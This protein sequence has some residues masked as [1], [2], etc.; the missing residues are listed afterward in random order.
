MQRV[1]ETGQAEQ[2][3]Q[4]Q[5]PVP[6]RPNEVTYWLASYFSVPLPGG[7]P[8]IGVMGLDITEQKKVEQRLHNANLLLQGSIDGTPDLIAAMGKDFRYLAVNIPYQQAFKQVFGKEVQAGTNLVDALAHLPEDQQNAKDLWERALQGERF[9]ITADFGDPHR[10]RR[11]FEMHFYPIYDAEG[12]IIAAG[13]IA[14]DVTERLK[15]EQALQSSIEKLTRSNEELAQFAFIASHDLQE[16]LRKIKQFGNTLQHKLHGN[17]DAD[18]QDSFERMINAVDWMQ[19]MIQDL[20]ELSWVNTLGNPF[21]DVD[22]SQVA[23]EVVSDLETLIH[24][25]KGQVIISFLPVIQADPIQIHEVLQNI[26][27]NALKFHQPDTPPVVKVSSEILK[28]GT[29]AV[30]K[31]LIRVEDNGIGFEEALFEQTLQPFRRLHGRNEYEGTGFGLAIV[32]KI[33]D[34]HQ[35]EIT[36]KSHPG[37][38]S[39]FI[40]TLPMK[41]T[42]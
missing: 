10:E 35:G 23:A 11:I 31:V 27:G 15:M 37:Q 18:T 14:K 19:K 25:T 12:K 6:G 36:A 2:N 33:I 32:K 17:L 3:M 40:I 24:R 41:Q 20:L 9:V 34:R 39:T 38:G 8:G 30:Q 21:V 42:G 4:V 5:S 13:E 29:Q 28:E 7:K 22:L 1:I 26:I 16:P